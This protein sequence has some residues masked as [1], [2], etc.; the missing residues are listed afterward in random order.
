[1]RSAARL[2][3][4]EVQRLQESGGAHLPIASL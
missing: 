1:M 3:Y 4:E 2:T